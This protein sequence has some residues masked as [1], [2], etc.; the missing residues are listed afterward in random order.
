MICMPKAIFVVGLILSITLLAVVFFAMRARTRADDR[1]VARLMC[2]N[3]LKQIAL[4]IRQYETVNG[5]FPPAYI[6]DRNAKPMHSWRVLLLPYLGQQDLYDRYRF[7][8]PWNSPNNQ[9]I[10][11]LVLGLYQCPAQPAAKEPTTNYVMVVGPDTISGGRDSRKIVEITDGLANT[12]MLVEVAD[13]NIGWAEPKD[14]E[15][16]RTNF[17]INGSKR[18]GISSYHVG[19]ANVALCDG[20]VRLLKNSTNPQLVKAMLTIN[21]GESAPSVQP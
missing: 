9:H 4:A 7:N 16:D 14:L 12:I 18:T 8:E 15:F 2:A 19:G 6:A 1:K 5:R 10:T 20:T 13:S 11:G 3:N 17:T 21:G